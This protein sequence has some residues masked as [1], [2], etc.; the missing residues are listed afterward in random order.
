MIK[1]TGI[2]FKSERLLG[3]LKEK[4]KKKDP[5]EVERQKRIKAQK[6]R[7]EKRRANFKG[8]SGFINDDGYVEFDGY[9]YLP[10]AQSRKHRVV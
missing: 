4:F 7:A 9:V 2:P 1:I 5:Q 3:K 10:N 6:K 8:Q